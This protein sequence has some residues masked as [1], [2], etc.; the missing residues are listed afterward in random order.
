MPKNLIHET[1]WL[2]ISEIVDKKDKEV[3]VEIDI[4][5]IIGGSFWEE[6]NADSINTKEKMRKELKAIAELKANRIIVNIDSPGG[7]VAHG[8]SI[9]DLLAQHSAKKTTRVIGMT[10]SIATVIAQVGDE[11]QISDNAL[12]LVHKASYGLLGMFNAN[13]LKVYLEDLE[14]IDKK[15]LNLYEKRTGKSTDEIGELMNVNNGQGKWLDSKEAKELGLVD[16]IFEPTKAAAIFDEKLFKKLNYP[17][18]MTKKAEEVKTFG[19]KFKEA[20]MAIFKPGE[21]Q[22]QVEIPKEVTEKMAEFDDKMK[23]LVD[24]NEIL[25]KRVEELE[26]E[27]N[28]TEETISQL[29]KDLS[30]KNSLCIDREAKITALETDINKLKAGSTKVPGV[31]AKEDP[32][33]VLTEEEKSIQKDL[34]KLRGELSSARADSF[35]DN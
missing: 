34:V 35:S 33:P 2:S 14:T 24:E 17:I 3:T 10:A 22:A 20:I 30:E 23:E 25:D 29:T 19:A 12:I 11:R 18:P 5:G 4:T 16:E 9:H 8:L 28:Q 27:K 1:P 7:S 15:I 32:E 13:D 31:I 6:D 21:G 26:T